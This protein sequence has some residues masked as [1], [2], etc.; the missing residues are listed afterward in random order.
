MSRPRTA[1]ELRVERLHAG[2]E[3]GLLAA[4]GDVRLE[5]GLGLV[6][7][8]LDPRGMDAAVLEQ[9][10]QRHAG[11]LAAD[12][13]EAGEDHRVRRVVD[14][15]VDAGQVLEGADVAALAP[16]DAALHVVGG[17]L[18]DADGRLGGMAGGEPL[19]DDGEDVADAPVGLPLGLLLDGADD[20]RAVVAGLV[21]E[22]LEQLLAGLRGRHA[23]DALER[24]DLL[25]ARLLERGRLLG[26]QR[27]RGRRAARA[28]SRPPPRAR[29][30]APPGGAGPHPARRS[31]R[32]RSWSRPASPRPRAWALAAGGAATAP[33]AKPGARR[34]SSAAAATRPTA[35]TIAPIRISMTS[36]P[37]RPGWLCP[38]PALVYLGFVSGRPD[39]A[40]GTARQGQHEGDAR[41]PPRQRAARRA[42]GASDRVLTPGGRGLVRRHG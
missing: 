13:V 24:E 26:Q 7:G 38:R 8:L 28:G 6:V 29:G 36:S 12:A 2:V 19:H 11:D 35:S 17:E 34:V 16:D 30:R 42:W 41:A 31:W 27:A 4:L 5:L 22:L 15:E 10:L 33:A 32:R 14:D 39:R 20:L 9:L 23:G 21:L 40:R 18:D 1:V 37:R 25:L 3:A